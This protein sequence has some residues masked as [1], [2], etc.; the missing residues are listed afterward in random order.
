M[1]LCDAIQGEALKTLLTFSLF[2]FHTHAVTQ[3]S[4]LKFRNSFLSYNNT[5]FTKIYTFQTKREKDKEKERKLER[6]RNR[7][8]RRRN[9]LIPMAKD[10]KIGVALDFSKSSKNALKWA[11][12]NLADKGDTFYIIHISNNSLDESRNQLWAQ[13]GSREF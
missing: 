8:R 2:K 11:L 9:S 7:R 1:G 3:A 12:E 10:R 4:L 13:S 5:A 6:E